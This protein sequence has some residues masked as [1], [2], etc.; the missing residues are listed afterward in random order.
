MSDFGLELRGAE[1]EGW[2]HTV[3]AVPSM[4]TLEPGSDS[5]WAQS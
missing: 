1:Q 2:Y 3:N 5:E 4:G